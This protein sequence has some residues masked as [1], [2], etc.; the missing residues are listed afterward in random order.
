MK[1]SPQPR[2]NLFQD[3]VK[4]NQEIFDFADGAQQAKYWPGS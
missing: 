3:L 1:S 4:G 2:L